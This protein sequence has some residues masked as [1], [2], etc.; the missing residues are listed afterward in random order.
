[1][2]ENSFDAI[3][4]GLTT[5]GSRRQLLGAIVGT[6]A[7]VLTGATVLEAR[8]QSQGKRKDQGKGKGKRQDQGRGQD[9]GQGYGPDDAPG[10][11]MVGLC[12]RDDETG[13]FTYME[14]PQPAVPGHQRHGDVLAEGPEDCDSPNEVE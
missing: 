4:K 7:A 9:Q 3:A 10:L 14:V 8:G 5:E 11:N 13:S 6:A 2:D 1:M 12:H